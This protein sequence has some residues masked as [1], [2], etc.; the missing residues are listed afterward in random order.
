MKVVPKDSPCPALKS[1]FIQ[2]TKALSSICHP[3]VV[4]IYDYYETDETYNIVMENCPN[5]TLEA[6]LD[7]EGSLSMQEIRLLFRPI[8]ESVASF[9]NLDISH[10]DIKPSNI[11]LDSKYRPKII[12]WGFSTSC[13]SGGKVTTYC[14]TFPFAAPECLRKIPYD[15]KMS[16]MWSIGVLLYVAAFGVHP[17][18]DRFDNVEVTRAIKGDYTIPPGAD[19]LFRALLTSLIQVD[20]LMR[21]SASHALNHPF[22]Q[23]ENKLSAFAGFAHKR[24][25]K[26]HTFSRSL[27]PTQVLYHKNRRR[28]AH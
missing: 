5:G 2:E 27:A 7:R 4:Q 15:P 12:D 28:T 24:N 11:A 13:P 1:M 23:V 10:R 22:F 20:P 6:L 8:L 21:L 25:T 14:G 19:S 26:S 17:F 16:D 18:K 3:N 9:H